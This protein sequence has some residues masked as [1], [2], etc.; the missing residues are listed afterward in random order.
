MLTDTQQ[1]YYNLYQRILPT[2]TSAGECRSIV[3]LI[4]E[5]YFQHDAVSITLNNPL[6]KKL[7]AN[8]L[9]KVIQRLRQQE[10][11]QYILEEAYFANRS[12][13]VNSSVLVP[14]PE[15]EE[16]VYTI[17]KENSIPNLHILDIG[18]GSGCIAITLAKELPNCRVDG[19]DISPKALEIA[20]ENA[21]RLQTSVNWLQQDILQD[22]LPDKQWDIFVSNPPYVCFSERIYMHKRVLDYEP[23]LALFVSDETPL[24]FYERIIQL[25]KNHLKE[26]GKI[27][28]E[29]NEQFASL[30]VQNLAEYK[31][32]NIKIEQ[33]VHGKNRWIRAMRFKK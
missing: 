4:L 24:L 7:P 11:I 20:S 10:P 14:R 13:Y 25:A 15:T 5:H 23:H 12:F 28:L 19:L 3:M 2:V 29:I 8:I 31:F 6:P 17:L 1:L 22:P 21:K 9:E 32:R 27:Y 26:F 18:T 30:I 33:D 16:M